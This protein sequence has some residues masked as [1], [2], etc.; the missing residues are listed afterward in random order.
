MARVKSAADYR[1]NIF[2]TAAVKGQKILR[3]SKKQVRLNDALKFIT[4]ECVRKGYRL[5]ETTYYY[6]IVLERTLRR[7]I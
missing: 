7:I 1:A 3:R 5:Y 2:T 4:D 6:V